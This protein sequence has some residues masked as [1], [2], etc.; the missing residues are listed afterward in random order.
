MADARLAMTS[1]APVGTTFQINTDGYLF[2]Y[3]PK[4]SVLSNGNYIVTWDNGNGTTAHF[5]HTLP[6]SAAIAGRV[7]GPNGA[8]VTGELTLLAASGSNDNFE[9]DIHASVASTSTGGFS[10]GW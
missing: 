10:V 3:S 5:G 4:A 8:P 6:V 7:I 9:D 2:G 1:V